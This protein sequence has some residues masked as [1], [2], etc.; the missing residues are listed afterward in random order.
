MRLPPIELDDRRF[1]DLVSEARLRINRACP[2]WTEHNVSDPG[3][4]LIELFAWMTEMT[5]YRLNRVPDK[6]HV[7]L[8]ELLGIRLDGPTGAHTQPALPAQRAGRPADR[9]PR[10]RRPRSARCAPRPRSRSSSRSTRTSRS[11]P[12]ARRPT[13]SSAAASSPD[14]GVVDG[15]AQAAGRRPAAVQRPAAGRR[16]ALPRL[17]G[18][19]READDPGRR[20]RPRWRAAPASTPRTRRCAGRS[21]AGDGNWE[22]A[23][24]LEDLTG[25]FN[26]GSGTVE[27]QCPPRSADRAAR[28]QAA[29]LAALPDRRQDARRR[30]HDLHAPARDLLDHRRAGRRAARRVALRRAPRARCS[31]LTRRHARPGR[32][33]CATRR[34]SSRRRARRSRSRTRSPATGS[35]GSCAR[36]SSARR[37]ST[38]TSHARRRL[39]RDRVRPGDPRDRRRLDAV[40]RGAAEG[41]GRCASAATATAAGARATSRPTT[42]NVA[43]QPDPRRRHGHQPASRRSAASTPS[44]SST[45]AQR[46]AMEIRTR[47]RAVTAEDFE[48]LAGEASP[49]VARAVCLAAQRRRAGAAAHR[50]ARLSRRPPA[51]PTTSSCP[52]TQLLQRGR[53][54]PRRAAPDRHA[55]SQL[56]PCRFRGLSVVRQPAGVAARRHRRASRRTSRTRSTRT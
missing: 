25:G 33:G 47:Y 14:I 37:R 30:D 46:A 2:E 19:H 26:Y 55:A 36:T 5:I 49:R 29:A 45:R 28:R 54:V 56:L 7:A 31:A 50:P 15:T 6:L 23:E 12:P 4:T 32:S 34:C 8:M 52:T 21:R 51:A 11:R 18:G 24:V 41:R 9:D 22:D 13:W 38:A 44:R 17:R 35:A 53:R 20:W 27:L 43:A 39:G 3:I 40:R 10:R 16:R 1:Q 42:L 48:F